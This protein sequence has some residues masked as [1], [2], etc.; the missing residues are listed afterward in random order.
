MIRRCFYCT[1]WIPLLYSYSMWNLF[2]YISF[3][4]GN[5]NTYCQNIYKT[6]F[7]KYQLKNK[8][9]LFTSIAHGIFNILTGQMIN[10]LYT[11]ENKR[12][13]NPLLKSKSLDRFSDTS[14][15]LINHPTGI[16][17]PPPFYTKRP[18]K[19]Q[20]PKFK[21]F[22][23]RHPFSQPQTTLQTSTLPFSLTNIPHF[24]IILIIIPTRNTT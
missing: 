20:I 5:F 9:T 14:T 16:T 12:P 3:P 22:P 1:F 17:S 10:D 18:N 21:L 11:T 23:K 8:I 24:L 7:I 15:T 19:L 6:I 13:K 4:T 2:F